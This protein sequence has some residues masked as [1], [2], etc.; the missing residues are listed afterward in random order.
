MHWKFWIIRCPFLWI[1]SP[2]TMMK[3]FFSFNNMYSTNYLHQH[4]F[5][6][7]CCCVM[8]FFPHTPRYCTWWDKKDVKWGHYYILLLL[9]RS[10]GAAN[11]PVSRPGQYLQ[12][13]YNKLS[14]GGDPHSNRNMDAGMHTFCLWYKQKFNIISN[15]HIKNLI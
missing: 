4:P 3:L 15:H 14:Q 10:Y 1:G 8:D 13:R 2:Q 12:Q 7:F 6:S 5:R 9:F 11:H